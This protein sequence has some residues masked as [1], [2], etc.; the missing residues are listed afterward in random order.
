VRSLLKPQ[1]LLLLKCF[2]QDETREQGPPGRYG[3]EDI[4]HFFADG[5]ELIEAR[6]TLFASSVQNDPPK[7]LFCVLGKS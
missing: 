6:S 3:E 2:H 1:G 5:F 7:A 4:R